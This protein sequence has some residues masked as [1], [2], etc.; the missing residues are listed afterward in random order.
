MNASV[1][2]RQAGQS[3]KMVEVQLSFKELSTTI[4]IQFF[5]FLK[6]YN[7]FWHP[8]YFLPFIEFCNQLKCCA[9]NEIHSQPELNVN[10]VL[11]FHT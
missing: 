5:P 3:K 6:V 4:S 11:F 7:F 2:M 1:T 8:L 9:F 10:Y